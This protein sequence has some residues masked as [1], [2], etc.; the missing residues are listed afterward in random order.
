MTMTSDEKNLI[1]MT[2]G[3]ISNLIQQIRVGNIE[4][5]RVALETFRNRKPIFPTL[6]T[7]LRLAII[8]AAEHA[9]R[10]RRFSEPEFVTNLLLEH[11]MVR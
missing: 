1:D 10:E 6:S 5:L 9:I 4:A 11:A 3:E 7:Y 2:I 8:D